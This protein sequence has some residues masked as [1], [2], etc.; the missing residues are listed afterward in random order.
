MSIGV[1]FLAASHPHCV[2]RFNAVR[3]LT[4]MHIAGVYDPDDAVADRVASEYGVRSFA[5]EGE[6]LGSPDVDVVVIEGTNIQNGAFAIIA[7]EAKRPFLLE[8]PGANNVES[9]QQVSEAVSTSGVVAQVGYHLRYSPAVEKGRAIINQ[10]LLGRITTG[11]FHCAVMSPWLTDAWFC[12]PDDRG[13]LVF[14][15]FC[16]MLDLLTVFVGEVSSI[17]GSLKKL[18]GV[19]DHPYEDSA[20]M[21]VE[22]G[23]VVVAGDVCGWEANDWIET[24]DIQLFGTEGTLFI[25][26]HKPWIRLYLREPRGGHPAGWSEWSDDSF[27]GELNYHREIADFVRA[28]EGGEKSLG[29]TVAEA[30]RVMHWI[31]RFYAAAESR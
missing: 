22:F 6:L 17:S 15:D 1:G 25:G 10:A 30:T 23:D 12:D 16:H 19:P 2:G 27:D 13:G 14:N 8:K 24:W 21:V 9:L 20:A 18:E 4:G 29:C 28:V 7:A 5:T 31:D 11:R 3:A 26:I